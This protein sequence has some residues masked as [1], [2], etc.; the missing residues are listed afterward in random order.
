MKKK[1]TTAQLFGERM[2]REGKKKEFNARVKEIMQETGKIYSTARWI[3]MREFGYVSQK[4][5]QRLVDE[6]ERKQRQDIEEEI[7]GEVCEAVPNVSFDEAL[8]QLPPTAKPF[9]EIDWVRAHPALSRLARLSDKTKGVVITAYDILHAPHGKAP[10]RGAVNILVDAANRPAKFFDE[11]LRKQKKESEVDGDTD[12][13][14]PDIGLDE[15][16]GMLA[17]MKDGGG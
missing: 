10:S 14:T 5:E 15:V 17:E 3:V 2:D 12:K 4:E 11:F 8:E 6:Y 16:R 9:V 13:E 7:F 1:K